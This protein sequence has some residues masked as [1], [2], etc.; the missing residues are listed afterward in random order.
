VR[1]WLDGSLVMDYWEPQ[2]SA[3]HYVD[4]VFLTGTH[5]LKVEY[6]EGTGSARIRFAIEW[7][8]APLQPPSTAPPS[9]PAPGVPGAWSAEYFNSRTLTGAPVLVRTDP[10]IDFNWGWGSPG[11]EVK[12]D[13]FS[14][15]WTGTFHFDA[16]RYRFSTTTDDGV[17][18]Y[19]DDQRVIN[20]WWPMRGTRVGY[21]TLAEGSHTVRVEY[22]ERTQAARAHASWQL[23]GA[24]PAAPAPVPV[25]AAPPVAWPVPQACVPGPLELDAW[26]LNTDKAAGGFV[27]EIF[28]SARGGDCGYTYLWEGQIQGGPTHASMTFE[29]FSPTETAM[30]GT[31][32]VTSGGQTAS[33]QLYIQP[34]ED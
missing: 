31:V 22:F 26:P 3:W 4:G 19:V 23:V 7:A 9:A 10:A 30:V 21:L 18:L 15:R 6:F 28:V 8:G 27:A 24:A 11:P 20:A 16:G 5:E 13:N 32:S 33:R 25:P 29:L 2:D 12:K 14:A 1:V 34:P 17:R